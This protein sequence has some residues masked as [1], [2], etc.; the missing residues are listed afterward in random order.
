[1]ARSYRPVVRDQEFLLPPN[2]AEWLPEDHLVWF[3]LDV[4]EQ[5]DTSRFHAA[6][7][8]GGAGR[9]GYD[10]DLLLALLLYSYAV[11][12][13]SSRRI[14][15][16]CVDHVAFRVVC[17][18][19]VPDHTTIARFRA[20][21]QDAFAEVFAQVLRLCANQGMVKVG[22]VA[23]DGT[24]IAANAARGAG[25]SADA[26]R[27]EARRLAEEIVA[28]AAAVDAAEGAAERGRGGSDDDLPPGFADR[29]GRAANIKKALEELERQDEAHR[30]VDEVERAHLNDRLRRLEAGEGIPGPVPAG[31]DPVVWW[32]TRIA[33]LQQILHTYQGIPGEKANQKRCKAR[34]D[35]KRAQQALERDRAKAAAGDLDRRGLAQRKR[36]RRDR[37]ARERG[38]TSRSV[39]VTDPDSR[40][41]THGSGGGSVQGYN[42]QIAVTDDHL[43][44][45]VHVSQDANDTH[46]FEPTLRAA[47]QAT[48]DLGLEIGTVL[49]DAGYFT[50]HNL[51]LAG[52]DRLIAPGKNREVLAEARQ[53]PASGTPPADAALK[54]A[55]RHRLRQPAA[56]ELYKRRSATVETVIAHLKDQA[57]LRRFS[58]R[59]LTAVTAELHLAAA[60]I[61]I[62]RMHAATS[63]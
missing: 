45:G 13:R 9:Q 29:G 38:G 4:V 2:M 22:T 46:C 33:G 27:Q 5:L 61:N 6:R 48:T 54:D 32:Q 25:R 20:E 52:P 55:M 62:R 37:K 34:S 53:A 10:P 21:H 56:A 44:V 59:G 19:D 18:Q 42:A 24:K 1:M 11:G 14:E 41:M 28:E 49:A 50:D 17:A 47:Q 60:V 35:L 26:V 51:T 12:E 36:D 57:G 7:R 16:L 8:T 3:V 40:L 30:K 39:N 23:I 43:V 31:M 63:T 15:R 58:R